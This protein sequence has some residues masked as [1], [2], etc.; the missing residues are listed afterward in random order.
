[1]RTRLNLCSLVAVAG[2][3]VAIIALANPI[4][5]PQA[6]EAIGFPGFPEGRAITVDFDRYEAEAGGQP[7]FRQ[8]SY[9]NGYSRR[10][11][12]ERERLDQVR[13]WL[14]L[15]AI[16]GSTLSEADVNRILFDVPPVRRGVLDSVASFEY[17]VTRSRAIGNGHVLALVPAGTDAE[18]I[19]H[20]TH[21][22][23]EER[24]NSAAIPAVFDIFEYSIDAAGDTGR[25]TRLPP[26]RGDALF[27]TGAG[28]VERVVHNVD[29]LQAFMN[30]VNDVTLARREGR[31]LRVGGRRI[32]GYRGIRLEDVAA[33]WQSEQSPEAQLRGSG[34]S[35]DPEFDFVDLQNDKGMLQ[36]TL[37]VDDATKAQQDEVETALDRKDLNKVMSVVQEVCQSQQNVA[38]CR[39]RY[40]G[41]LFHH[42]F[43]HAR[44]D[45]KLKGT[46]VGMVLFYTDLLMKMWSLDYS[47]STPGAGQ[48]DDFPNELDMQV[49]KVYADEVDRFPETR[50]WLGS[51]D[52]GFQIGSGRQEILF[53]RNATRVF[54]IPHDSLEN[55]DVPN[56]VEPHIY[57]RVF[58][59]WWNAH[60]EETAR[61]EQE[62]QRLNEIMKWSQIV[63]WLNADNHGDT[64]AFLANVPIAHDNRFPEWVKKHPELT[65][66]DWRA[67][68]FY[69][70]NDYRSTT[71]ALP[72]LQ[73]E[74]FDHFGQTWYW[75]G[76]VSL[77]RR[78]AIAART[79]LSESMT[80][81]N[82]RA[83]LDYAGS[84]GNKLRTLE[85]TE[86]E[87]STLGGRATTVAKPDTAQRLRSLV[88][89]FRTETFE[90]TVT[91]DSERFIMAQRAKDAAIGELRI[92]RS[93]DGFRV[94]W[95]GRDID[96]AQALAREVSVSDDM[97]R[98]LNTRFVDAFIKLQNDDYLVKSRGAEGWARLT[99]STAEDS[100]VRPGFQ[101]RISGPGNGA[102][103][104]DVALVRDD[105]SQYLQENSYVAIA[106]DGAESDSVMMVSAARPPP[107]AVP[108]SVSYQGKPIALHVDS[109]AHKIYVKWS[110]VLPEWRSDPSVLRSLRSNA[111]AAPERSYGT[112]VRQ[113]D[114]GDF[115]SAARALVDNPANT[116]K[117]LNGHLSNELSTYD[118]LMR[119]G[120]IL[121]ARQDL[122]RL[123]FIQGDRPE[124]TLRRALSDLASG[125][126]D[127]AIA[128]AKRVDGLKIP[129]AHR[130]FD[131]IDQLIAHGGAPQQAEQLKQFASYARIAERRASNTASSLNNF[132]AV[133][134]DQKFQLELKVQKLTSEP[135]SVAELVRDAD[136]PLYIQDTPGL[137]ALDFNPATS[138]QRLQALINSGQVSVE[139]VQMADLATYRP[140]RIV[141]TDTNTTL[142]LAGF[143]PNGILRTLSRSTM[144]TRPNCD[145]QS[146]TN[147]CQRAYVIV[148]RGQPHD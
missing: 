50:L 112:L 144:L 121:Q 30:E 57:D 114:T 9:W 131:E 48:V 88:G 78:Q 108:T 3:L 33:I 5:A 87:F 148:D 20:L 99:R 133:L 53:A 139:R 47:G 43:Q 146:A 85:K 55:R 75:E 136:T 73:S 1:M 83:N 97:E 110:D 49:A 81:V 84:I 22:A 102:R 147:G 80:L 41:F 134:H 127:R 122:E 71:E 34:F 38:S 95:V 59:T 104:V 118:Q 15:T 79:E 77:A 106:S 135:S 129:D 145:D 141:Q 44:Y 10:A 54:A 137:N 100:N 90:R 40:R 6:V 142:Q 23:D 72:I 62:Y 86:Y 107:A 120:D 126:P 24:K 16:S 4:L 17:D 13:D 138:P 64:L 113:I 25:L 7:A 92:A 124:L 66:N 52:K 103:D 132:S 123:L 68:P 117:V 69:P 140:S 32:E 58:M 14:L 61:Y 91:R 116:R 70:A 82:R 109:S 94:G 28:Y 26:V 51:L 42:R 98:A 93:P 29:E 31:A 27:Q 130:F 45:G 2:C 46:E 67:V 96:A 63:G 18:R 39:R 105:F 111:I 37:L 115:Q 101:A 74:G 56:A 60:Y 128:I 143:N 19:G 125:K 119:N 65:F 12:G 76:G 35:L 8:A 89:E 36:F 21:V 11:T